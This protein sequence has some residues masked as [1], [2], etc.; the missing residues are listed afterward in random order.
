MTEGGTLN[1]MRLGW[2]LTILLALAGPAA[3][4]QTPVPPDG[5]PV[6]TIPAQRRN[7]PVFARGI[8][9]VQAFQSV[10]VRSRVDGTIDRIAFV[11]GQEVKAGDL[12]AVIDPRPYQSVLD[13]AL[14]KRAADQALLANSKR[15]LA[16]YADLVRSDFAS[17]Q[18]VDTQIASVAQS[19]ANT[20]GDDAAVATARLNLEFCQVK[21]PIGGRIGLRLVDTG[22]LVHAVDQTGIVSIAQVHPISLLF[23][24]PQA[25]L[26]DV[27]AAMHTGALTVAAYSQDDQKE[28]SRG[29][30]LTV[31]N[32]IDA[33]TGTIR[34]KAVFGNADDRLWPGQFVHA[35]LLLQ[36]EP[37][38]VTV[39]SASVQRGPDGLYVYVVK[40]DSTAVVRPIEVGQDDGSIAIVSSGLDDGE[41]VVLTGQSRLTNG[42]RVAATGKANERVGG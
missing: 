15:D 38:V 4:A 24:L 28:L 6:T 22:N 27:Q 16:R 18:S 30:L 8:G 33:A 13:Q 11:E 39:P 34:I 40:P 26:P 41:V 42:T 25:S 5:V 1:R 14:A 31:D 10:L 21:A 36:T 29:E 12:L 37:N 9:T 3:S 19:T 35:R 7:V 2:S 17:R 32:A 20:Q 23:T